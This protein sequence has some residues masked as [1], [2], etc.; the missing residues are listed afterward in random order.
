MMEVPSTDSVTIAVHDMGGTGGEPLLLCHA[1]GLHAR[2]YEP[3]AS[4]LAPH[5]HVWGLDFRAHGDSTVPDNE[6]FDWAGFADDLLNVIDALAVRPISVFGHSLGGGVSLLA[7]HRRPGTL[8]SAF[9]FEPI[10]IPA[11]EGMSPGGPSAMSEGARRRRATFPS[12]ATALHRY[13]SRPPLN[14]LRADALYAYVEHG[15][16]ETADGAVE[17]K[18]LPE[19]EAATFAAD[20]KPTLEIAAEVRT[21]TT[22]A[23]GT[24]A[25]GWTPATFGAAI[26][27]AL[28]NGRLEIDDTLGHFGPLQDPVSVAASILAAGHA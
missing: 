2:A 3:L 12:T 20:G 16:R 19:H 8:K 17:L 7:E 24:T 13:A 10:V 28:P 9:F 15:F 21:P 11:V 25:E 1:T 6:R 26:V 5:F 4:R 23:I 22:I 18:C 27:D 14:E